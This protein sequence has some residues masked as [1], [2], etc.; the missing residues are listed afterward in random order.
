M[1]LYSVLTYYWLVLEAFMAD[2]FILQEKLVRFVMSFM[3][4][5]VAAWWAEHCLS[6]VLFP[7]PTWAEFEAEYRLWFVEENEQDQDLTKLESHS[8][9]QGYCDIYWYTDDFEEL[10]VTAG[11][12][13]CLDPSTAGVLLI[14]WTNEWN[15]AVQA[16]TTN[17][18][19]ILVP[20]GCTSLDC[21]RVF[22]HFRLLHK[23]V[24]E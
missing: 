23:T 17:R 5:D 19:H 1:F 21:R 18:I 10:A 11:E 22:M 2:R 6:A 12:R 16:P 20:P 14:T 13:L 7:F 9:F 24:K 3:S 15:A 4:K 8:Y